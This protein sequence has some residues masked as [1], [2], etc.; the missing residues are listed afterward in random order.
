VQLQRQLGIRRDETAWYLLYKLRR[1]MIAPERGLVTGEVEA[2]EAF[3]GGRNPARRLRYYAR[4]FALVEV[5]AT[6]YALPAE[7]TARA[8][9]RADPGRL[10]LQHQ[11]IQPVH[12]PP[13]PSG[14]AASRPA[15]GRR[16]NRQGPGLRPRR[17]P[18]PGR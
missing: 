18:G 17:R 10:H 16:E 2:G 15:P 9:G 11:G 12:P 7:Q 13:H 5:D 14:R 3:A 4:Q 6:Y 1:A 8:V